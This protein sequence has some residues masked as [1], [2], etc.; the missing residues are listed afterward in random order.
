MLFHPLDS[1]E[2]IRRRYK[3]MSI[4][5]SLAIFA[6]LIVL[7]YLTV[8]LTHKPFSPLEIAETDIL[9]EI[10]VLIAPPISFCVVCYGLISVMS[11]EST[12]KEIFITVS[13]CYVPYLIIT[14]LKIILSWALTLNENGLF[15]G[16]ETI[17]YAWIIL[18]IFTSVVRL[19]NFSIPKTIGVGVMSIIGVALMWIVLVLAFAFV[20][21]IVLFVRELLVELQI[22]RI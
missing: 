10:A 13:Y 20:F 8:L 18:L 21:Q 16:L 12:F 17:M 15:A 11:G 3:R 2:I 19:N 5:P 14:P 9:L 6:L 22:I 7:R 4:L 1:F